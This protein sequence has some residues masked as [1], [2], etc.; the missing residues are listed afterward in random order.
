LFKQAATVLIP[1]ALATSHAGVVIS[2]RHAGPEVS[3]RE[4]YLKEKL[5]LE[6]LL[7][8]REPLL[9]RAVF[10]Y[11]IAVM[12]AMLSADFG[13]CLRGPQANSPLLTCDPHRAGSKIQLAIIVLVY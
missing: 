3:L 1:I 4:L 8:W 7:F 13:L 11:V 6:R 10:G 9:D 5:I 12:L 2:E